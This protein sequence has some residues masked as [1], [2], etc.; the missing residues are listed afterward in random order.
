MCNLEI[1]AAAGLGSVNCFISMI[2]YKTCFE[3][4]IRIFHMFSVIVYIDNTFASPYRGSILVA[5]WLALPTFDQEVPGPS[6]AS[7]IK[8]CF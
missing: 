5:D 7:F 6:V 1:I 3:P 4:Q 8:Y 2:F